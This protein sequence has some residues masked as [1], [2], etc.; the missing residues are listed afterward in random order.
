M[1]N[2]LRRLDMKLRNTLVC[3]LAIVLPA[4]AAAQQARAITAVALRAGPDRDY[5]FV[6]SYGPGT[7]LMVQGC[8]DGFGW[9]D[10]IAPNGFRGWVYAG[11]IA[12]P[13]QRREVPVLGY[14][15]LIGIPI[16]TFALGNYWGAHY[17][18]RSWYRDRDRWERYNPRPVYRPPVRPLPGPRPPPVGVPGDHRP[19]TGGRP[20]HEGRPPHDGGRPSGGIPQQG[21]VVRDHGKPVAIVKPPTRDRNAPAPERGQ[22]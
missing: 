10:V 14:G 13:Y 6:A 15:A 7:P 3:A 11:D 18:N 17:N 22:Q 1:L 5:P 2:P 16:I 9:C 4:I 20:P 21:A 12:Y 19:P 8:T